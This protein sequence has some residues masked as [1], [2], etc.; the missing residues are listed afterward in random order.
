MAS[1]IERQQRR[2]TTRQRAIGGVGALAVIVAASVL[3]LTSGGAE[4]KKR[5]APTTTTTTQPGDFTAATTLTSAVPE[6][7]VY[8]APDAS[9]P[10]VTRLNELTRYGVVRTLLMTG[11]VPGWYE[12]L[13]PIRPNGT[14]GWV[15]TEE[16]TTATS[17]YEIRVSL[18]KHKLK[19]FEKG[20]K[21]LESDVVIGKAE[22]PTPL[23]TF[24]VTDPVNLATRRG[25]DYGAFA[26]GISGFSEVLS[27]FEDGPGQLAVHGTP[28]PEEV[29]QDLSNGCVRV[30]DDVILKMAEIVPLGTPVNLVA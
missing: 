30:P 2:R 15:K 18:S 11:T 14:K 10:E 8:E 23:G 5:A 17:D 19:L 9:A 13:L 16:V 1:R 25:S 27:E 4:E 3:V 29:G 22:T 24:Y 21:I 20:K 28:R 7:I 26:L 6:L 12:A